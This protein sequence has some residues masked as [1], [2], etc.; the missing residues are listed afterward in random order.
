MMTLVF[1]PYV[2]L[3]SRAAFLEQSVCVLDAGRTLGL[4]A[5][6]AFWR[7]ALP[8]AR[9]AVAGGLALVLMET[10][11]DFDLA[12][13]FAVDTFVTG[14]YRTWLG[15]GKQIGRAHV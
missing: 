15:Q 12:S 3:L 10:L 11:G 4:G 14:I 5:W 6:R 1:Y 7:V 13:F 9:P 8:L 2:Y